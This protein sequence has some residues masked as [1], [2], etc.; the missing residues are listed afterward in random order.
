MDKPA[1]CPALCSSH[2][3]GDKDI[4]NVMLADN[5]IINHMP[6]PTSGVHPGSLVFVCQSE[7]HVHDEEFTLCTFAQEQKDTAVHLAN[8]VL[9][10]HSLPSTVVTANV[11]TEVAKQD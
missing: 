11:G 9:A 2:G 4:H 1:I 5:D 10:K 3:S 8:A 7:H 6:L